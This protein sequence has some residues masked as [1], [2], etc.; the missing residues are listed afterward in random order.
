VIHRHVV[1]HRATD[2]AVT[3]SAIRVA[4]TAV[5]RLLATRTATTL[6]TP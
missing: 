5:S 4:I 3:R 6:T 2:V 1:V